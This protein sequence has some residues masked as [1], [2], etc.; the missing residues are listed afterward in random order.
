MLGATAAN[1]VALLS[2]EFL[3]LVGLALLIGLP[4]SWWAVGQ[5]L[6]NFAYNIGVRWWMF[7]IPFFVSITIALLTVSYHSLRAAVRNPVEALRYE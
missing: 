6:E 2:R 7:A 3:W 1:I 4:I 5:W